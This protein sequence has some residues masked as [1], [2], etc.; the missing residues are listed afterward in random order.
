VDRPK[1]VSQVLVSSPQLLFSGAEYGCFVLKSG[2]KETCKAGCE[3]GRN[4]KE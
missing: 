2:L 3:N 4:S 1:P